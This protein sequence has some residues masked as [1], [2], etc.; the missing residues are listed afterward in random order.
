MGSLLIVLFFMTLQYLYVDRKQ[1]F[2]KGIVWFSCRVVFIKLHFG[3]WSWTLKSFIV[4]ALQN[5]VVC[6]QQL[7]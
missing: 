5:A 7:C 2:G 3:V 4:L 6:L 1:Y